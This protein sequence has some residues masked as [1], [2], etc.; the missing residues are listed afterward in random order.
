MSGN[1]GDFVAKTVKQG[2][3]AVVATKWVPLVGTGSGGL[4]DGLLPLRA[5]RHL[6]MQI[7]ANPGGSL[8]LAYVQKNQ[9]GSFTTPDADG[10]P[11][12]LATNYPG[13]TIFYEPIGDAVQV[14]GRL[15]KKKGF[16]DSSIR[17]I[18][19]EFR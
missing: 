12:K 7:K 17:V 11:V 2:D 13:N 8:A 15:Y 4:T 16:T 6:R 19:T 1:Y 18:V 10:V 14:Y 9:D 3:V 5:R